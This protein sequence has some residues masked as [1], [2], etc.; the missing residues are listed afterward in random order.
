MVRGLGYTLKLNV[1]A[2]DAWAV[3]ADRS[4][5]VFPKKLIEELGPDGA[6]AAVAREVA[7]VL[8]SRPS[9][10]LDADPIRSLAQA[11]A[12]ELRVSRMLEARF[13]GVP[14]LFEAGAS[15]PELKGARVLQLAE[16]VRW[17]LTHPGEKP[18]GTLDP[19]LQRLLPKVLAA[20]PSITQPPP[21]TELRNGELTEKRLREEAT[22]AEREVDA[23]LMPIF[24]ALRDADLQDQDPS[25]S[26]P[27]SGEPSDDPPKQGGLSKKPTKGGSPPQKPTDSP[28][29]DSPESGDPSKDSSKDSKKGTS[30]PDK[31]GGDPSDDSAKGDPK[32][33]DDDAAKSKKLEDAARKASQKYSQ[34]SRDNTN[35][36][37]QGA[38]SPRGAQDPQKTPGEAPPPQGAPEPPP[39]SSP[40]TQASAPDSTN[41]PPSSSGANVEGDGEGETPS[42]DSLMEGMKQDANAQG[43]VEYARIKDEVS[44]HLDELV[45]DLGDLI[46]K[47]Q[48]PRWEGPYRSGRFSMDR[49]IQATFREQA[50]GRAEPLVFERRSVPQKRSAAF[51]LLLD[52]SLSTQGETSRYIRSTAVLFMEALDTLG[53]R[54][55]V[56]TFGEKPHLVKTL[57]RNATSN[58]RA[59]VIEAINATE[60]ATHIL[61]ATKASMQV[62]GETDASSRIILV[63]TDGRVSDE[64]RALVRKAEQQGFIV[65]GVGLGPEAREVEQTFPRAVYAENVRSLP[66]KFTLLLTQLMQEALFGEPHAE[67]D[68][69]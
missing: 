29:S 52:N 13:P 57:E 4:T 63:L 40:P 25:D 17:Q 36:K 64:Q 35:P 60:G 27:D 68:R 32:A 37:T 62:L 58:D 28:E 45:Q 6:R 3:S 65:V 21:T 1:Q 44:A 49:Y 14:A 47:D 8:Y 10:G 5:L 16:I 7:K 42:L 48:E 9:P 53:I 22:R 33:P 54:N 41:R 18:P 56:L 15:S 66:A 2:G 11:V 19:L 23:K 30:S 24:Q 38:Q 31:V 12:Q 39:S 43:I 61:A 26:D 69:S 34:Q 46:K 20:L 59:K 51:M 55:G 67:G 50:T